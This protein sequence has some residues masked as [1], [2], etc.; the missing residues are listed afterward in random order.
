MY[1]GLLQDEI[2]LSGTSHIEQD[3]SKPFRCIR[4]S[5]RM[6]FSAQV[7]VIYCQDSRTIG[8]E[9]TFPMYP[10]L[11]KNEILLLGTS[12]LQQDRRKLFRCTL[13]SCRMKFFSQVLLMQKDRSKPFRCT[14][15]SCRIKFFSQVLVGTSY[16]QQDR[17]KHFRSILGS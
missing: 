4:D 6:K 11:L 1:P 2:L 15:D 8:Q 12:Q 16:I 7:L 13:D 17:S 14:L 3:R 10:R 9:Q 5:C